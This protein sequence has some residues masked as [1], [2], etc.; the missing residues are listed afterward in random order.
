MRIL[1]DLQ[2]A[3]FFWVDGNQEDFAE[4]IENCNIV[5]VW[6]TQLQQHNY[7][8]NIIFIQK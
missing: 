4:N 6:H 7:M 2:N 5:P 1:G 8:V 3:S